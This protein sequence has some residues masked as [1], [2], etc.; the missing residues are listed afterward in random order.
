[1]PNA[2]PPPLPEA[3]PLPVLSAGLSPVVGM[4]PDAETC[5]NCDCVLHGRFC[6]ECGQDNDPG[7]HLLGDNIKGVLTET[8]NFEGR[9]PRTLADL[10]LSP[11][12]LL[13]GFKDGLSVRY[14]PPFKL[15]LVLSAAF[16]LLLGWTNVSIYQL[17]HIKLTER[18]GPL[19]Y[20]EEGNAYPA[21]RDEVDLYLQP[22]TQEEPDLELERFL[23]REMERATPA[24]REEIQNYRNY[25]HGWEGLN[26]LLDAWFPRLIWLLMPA[27]AFWLSRIF[28]GR[29]FG[30]HLIFS[31]WAYC[32]L[33]VLLGAVAVFN[34]VF[35][36]GIDGTPILPVYQVYLTLGVKH[37][38]DQT[39]AQAIRRSIWHTLDYIGLVWFPFVLILGFGYAGAKGILGAIF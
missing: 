4:R 8:L 15:F 9:T 18:P 37:F 35:H 24:Q 7:K 20:D 23:D 30:E 3:A 36:T 16:F 21:G 28:K 12:R 22:L 11:K 31:M 29:L 39:W 26:S 17:H 2:E 32:V 19:L 34:T 10:M 33:F 14:V 25:Y 1:M 5:R 27:H 6:S 13:A 38:Y